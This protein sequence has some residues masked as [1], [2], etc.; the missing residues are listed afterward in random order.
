MKWNLILC[1][2]SWVTE[3]HALRWNGATATAATTR[4]TPLAGNDADVSV[5][6]ATS[7]PPIGSGR[8]RMELFKRDTTTGLSNNVCGWVTGDQDSAFT[9]NAPSQTCLWNPSQS[10]V[11]CGYSTDTP[12]VTSCFDY[13]AASDCVGP[14][15]SNTQNT[16]C[17][18]ANPYCRTILFPS[19]YTMLPCGTESSRTTTVEVTY[20]SFITPIPLPR[21]LFPNGT[22]VYATQ[23]S[24]I[25]TNT[26]PPDGPSSP[27]ASI[28]PAALGGAVL[29][30]GLP[31]GIKALY[32]KRQW[33][34]AMRADRLPDEREA[35]DMRSQDLSSLYVDP[36]PPVYLPPERNRGFMFSQDWYG[37]SRRQ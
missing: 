24:P 16:I 29:L 8:L 7:P 12:F 28:I 10:Y 1:L 18:S 21:T 25:P 35:M 11:G 26:A 31:F 36:V 17:P 34:R 33:R 19:S 9:C 23:V 20:S 15:A 3:V 37:R 22:L 27:L 32:R 5:P 14:C 13:S 2:G 30:A 6:E 4:T